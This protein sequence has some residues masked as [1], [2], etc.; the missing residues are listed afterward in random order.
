MNG[1]IE[2]CVVLLVIGVGAWL[3]MR[4]ASWLGWS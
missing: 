1:V 2:L 3:V 4:L